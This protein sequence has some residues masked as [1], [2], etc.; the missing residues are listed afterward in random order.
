MVYNGREGGSGA[1]KSTP[2]LTNS[3]RTSGDSAKSMV[4]DH[5]IGASIVGTAATVPLLCN[6]LQ[7]HP[8]EQP[9]FDGVCVLS[10]QHEQQ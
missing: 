6:S 3:K 8:T 2:A 10:W 4:A 9:G 7:T 5:I 1:L